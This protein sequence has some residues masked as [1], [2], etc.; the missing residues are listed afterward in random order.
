MTEID[1]RTL[2]ATLRQKQPFANSV[3]K[4]SYIWGK[5]NII[6]FQDLNAH[7]S[8]QI[9]HALDD[10]ATQEGVAHSLL[11]IAPDGTGKSHLIGRLRRQLLA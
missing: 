9:L 4:D 3:A 7:A 6:D 5:Q 11:I 2:N 10:V 8:N 1:I